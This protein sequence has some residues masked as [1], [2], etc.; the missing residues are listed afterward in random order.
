VGKLGYRGPR[1]LLDAV[2]RLLPARPIDLIDLGCGTGLC[3]TLF[4]PI[5]RHIVGVDLSP[6]MLDLARRT[7]SYD[8]L[9]RADIAAVLQ[10]RPQS[11]DLVLAADVFI[12][13]GELAPVLAAARDALRLGGLFAFTLET[14]SRG[15]YVL[16]RT[17]RYAHSLA[18]VRRLAIDA[19]LIERSVSTGFLRGGEEGPVTGSVVV[20]SRP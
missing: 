12:Y 6:T 10:G 13:V 9:A 7:G 5:A 16:E 3:G 1:L 20:L 18:Y 17:R 2:R 11:A 14:T 19:G 8:E 15:D 4:R